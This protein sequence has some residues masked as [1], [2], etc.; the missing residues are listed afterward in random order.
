[1]HEAAALVLKRP[2][3]QWPV[4]KVVVW[5]LPLF[6]LALHGFAVAVDLSMISDLLKTASATNY[7]ARLLQARG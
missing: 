1:M 3:C 5:Q 4:L 6:H 7:I 2:V